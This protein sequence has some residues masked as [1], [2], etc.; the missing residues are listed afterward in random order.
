VHV[1][2]DI[3]VAATRA[4]AADPVDVKSPRVTRQNA[5]RPLAHHPLAPQQ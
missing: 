1:I 3:R 2:A 4:D 5:S